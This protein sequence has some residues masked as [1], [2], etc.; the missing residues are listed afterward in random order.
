MHIGGNN[1]DGGVCLC[2]HCQGGRELRWLISNRSDSE[3]IRETWYRCMPMR[4]DVLELNGALGD[5]GTVPLRR[6][7]PEGSSRAS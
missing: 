6:G 5:G 4:R 1:C 2:I 3:P 7:H